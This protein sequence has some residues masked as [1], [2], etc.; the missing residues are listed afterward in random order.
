VDNATSRHRP[1]QSYDRKVSSCHYSKESQTQRTQLMIGDSLR[2]YAN[3]KCK[4]P[5]STLLFEVARETSVHRKS[6]LSASKRIPR[7][8]TLFVQSVKHAE[9][10]FHSRSAQVP[11]RARISAETSREPAHNSS[12]KGLGISQKAVPVTRTNVL[13]LPKTR[14]AVLAPLISLGGRSMPSSPLCRESTRRLTKMRDAGCAE[15]VRR[16]PWLGERCDRFCDMS[17]GANTAT[18]VIACTA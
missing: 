12:P 15:V 16:L 4:T 1:Y 7:P 17:P 11:P 6:T 18:R 14:T 5:H 3:T 13:L 2:T 8:S 9:A 10:N